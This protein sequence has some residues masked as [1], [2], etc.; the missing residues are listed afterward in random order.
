MKIVSSHIQ[1]AQHHKKSTSKKLLVKLLKTVYKYK[2]LST[3]RKIVYTDIKHYLQG[4]K[5]NNVQ[6][7]LVRNFFRWKKMKCYL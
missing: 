1:A 4:N 7:L 5:D 2:I 6:I 3:D